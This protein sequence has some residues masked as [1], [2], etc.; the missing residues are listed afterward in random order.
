MRT[1]FKRV[2]LRSWGI[3]ILCGFAG[4]LFY[5]DRQTLSVL[6]TTLQATWGLSDIDYGWLVA[7]FMTPYTLCYLIS[8]RLIDR[9][10]T[11]T[12]MP[13]FLLGMSLATVAGGLAQGFWSLGA[14]RVVL[15]LAEAG[16]IPA[17]MVAIVTWFP[18]DMRGTATT[19][20]K[21]LTVAGRILV[22]PFAAGVAA[23]QSWRW[24]FIIPG[25]LG[26]VCAAL[27]WFTD[28]HAPVT[29]RAA[30][31]PLP[32]YRDV[33]ANQ[34]IRGL[35]LARLVS[36]P[37]WFFLMFWQPGFLQE[38]LGLSLADLGRLGW[39]PSVAA[40]PFIMA[41]G[42]LSDGWVRQGAAPVQS[43]VRVLIGLTVIAPAALLLTHTTSVPLALA[44]LS[45]LQVMTASWLSFSGLLMSD[46]V[47][48]RMVGTTVALM[49][50]LGA[51][52]GAAFNLVAGPLVQAFGYDHLM[53][54][55]ALLHPIAAVIL[56]RAYSRRADPLAGA[57]PA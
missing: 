54:V 23:W 57:A 37:L 53:W 36:D 21:P 48:R 34:A 51:M 27:W 18:A 25:L 2:P 32:R 1:Y 30:A 31:Q 44:L 6:K 50:A 43:R 10:G 7:A 38:R 5:V 39:I 8:G 33:L 41:L 29:P 12:M 13:L 45:L 52:A 40:L 3:I 19:I 22:V 11:R 24:A 20:N 28:K 46:L 26:A 55:G 14:S 9:W 49:S 47:P 15:G 56:W 17:V 42:H 4:M 16:I 35:L